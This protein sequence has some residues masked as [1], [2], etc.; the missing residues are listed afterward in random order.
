MMFKKK[1]RFFACDGV[2]VREEVVK[3][4]TGKF[5]NETAQE[6]FI[7]SEWNK[8]CGRK[9]ESL[10]NVTGGWERAKGLFVR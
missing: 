9:F 10:E 7:Q 1:Y 5:T 3:L 8:W 2:T 4:D 6:M